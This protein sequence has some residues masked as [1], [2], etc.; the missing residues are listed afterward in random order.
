MDNEKSIL[1]GKLIKVYGY[2]GDL[3]LGL[4][5]GFSED[6]IGA[7]VVFIKIEGLLAPFF[8]SSGNI[9][10][11]DTKSLF[12]KFEDVDSDTQAKEYIGCE[13][14]ILSEKKENV[15]GEFNFQ[16]YL[17][18][19]VVDSEYGEIGLIKEIMPF[20]SNPVIRIIKN[21]KEILIPAQES[22]FISADID[23][24]RVFVQLPEGLIDIYS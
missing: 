9:R 16:N 18:Y 11:R 10:E 6:I 21:D 22:F 3:I 13:V 23:N 19:T 14:Y 5:P 8:I 1:A 17:S 7:K 2:Q 12:V 4:V 24:K 15:S 20:K